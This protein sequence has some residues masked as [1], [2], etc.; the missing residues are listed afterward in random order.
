MLSLYIGVY[1]ALYEY[2]PQTD[3]ELHI[4]TGDILYLLEKSEVDDW[5]KVKKRV[6]PEGDEEVEEPVGLVPLN[7]IEE[8]SKFIKE[9]IGIGI[10]YK[11]VKESI[12]TNQRRPLLS[13][14]PAHFTIITSRQKKNLHL[15]KEIS[16][17]CMM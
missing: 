14:Q 4:Q 6:L 1:R 3:E 17:T 10:C 12:D 16:L 11:L 2:I 7:Y 8:V 5:W 15:R 13:T 9:K